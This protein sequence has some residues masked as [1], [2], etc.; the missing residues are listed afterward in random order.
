MTYQAGNFILK[1]GQLSAARLETAHPT[2][3]VNAEHFNLLA[4]FTN[5]C[6]NTSNV[7]KIE[8]KILF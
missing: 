1:L 4:E 6:F 7:L 8:E 2:I 5:R 3:L